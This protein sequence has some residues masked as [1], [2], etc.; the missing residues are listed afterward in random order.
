MTINNLHK[1]VPVYS[2]LKRT[3]NYCK[4]MNYAWYMTYEVVY[5]SAW[6]AYLAI[7]NFSLYTGIEKDYHI[8]LKCAYRYLSNVYNEVE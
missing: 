1:W 7:I 4:N 2:E 3:I 8:V 6:T 5:R